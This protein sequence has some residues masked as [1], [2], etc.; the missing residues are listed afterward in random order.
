M[1]KDSWFNQWLSPGILIA[2]FAACTGFWVSVL[3]HHANS[4]IHHTD[5]EL[6]ATYVRKDVDEAY[7]AMLDK[8]IASLNNTVSHIESMLEDKRDSN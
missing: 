7:C 5:T 1:K 6:N 8:E 2:I 4:D 3:M